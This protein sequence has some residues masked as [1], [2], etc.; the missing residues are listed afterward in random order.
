ML[1]STNVFETE[2]QRILTEEIE[3]AR[4]LLE[5]APYD[6]VAAFERQRERIKT[7]R[8]VAGDLIEEA[9]SNVEKRMRG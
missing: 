8:L 6:S 7:L 3:K 4:D 1:T 2:L 5:A 9:K